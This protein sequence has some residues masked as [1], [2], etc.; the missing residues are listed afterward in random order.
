MKKPKILLLTDGQGWVIDRI[1][2]AIKYH[3]D[4]V[5]QEFEIDIDYYTQGTDESIGAKINSGGYDLVHYQN[6]DIRAPRSLIWAKMP[7]IISVRS[8]RYPPHFPQYALKN[9][10]KKFVIH[11]ATPV[12]E[13]LFPGSVYL[14]DPIFKQY[15]FPKPFKVGTAY[16]NNPANI[17][18]KGVPLIRQACSEL[19]LELS[20]AYGNIGPEAMQQWYDTLDLYVC[21]SENEAFSTPVMECLAMNKPVITTKVG[22]PGT[23]GLDNIYIERSVEGIKEG[24]LRHY[25]SKRVLPEFS[26][27]ETVKA[28]GDFYKMV[29]RVNKK[30]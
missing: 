21:A 25:T 12:L 4:T 19:G 22:V 28:F 6:W 14:P 8:H 27:I 7:V 24:I 18:Y 5:L 26:E 16:Q 11:A 15:N 20:E 3:L 10:R 9:N 2:E 1:C 17:E 23:L 13:R 29:M 30:S